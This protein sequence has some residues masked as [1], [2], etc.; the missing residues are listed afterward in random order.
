MVKLEKFCDPVDFKDIL[1]CNF[2]GFTVVTRRGIQTLV[3]TFP[4]ELPVAATLPHESVDSMVH[5][6]T[7]E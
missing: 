3:L 4:D 6:C 1:D 7:M 5:S 2:G